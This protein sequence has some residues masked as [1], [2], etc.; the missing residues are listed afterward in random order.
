MKNKEII[1]AIIFVFVSYSCSNTSK[2]GQKNN[3][4]IIKL[5]G[6]TLTTDES[7]L[8]SSL[9]LL[10]DSMFY[11]DVF[12]SN[13]DTLIDVRK[14]NGNASAKQ[15]KFLSKGIGPF[16]FLIPIFHYDKNKCQL[17]ILER[18]R[19][20]HAYKID[21]NNSENI[22]NPSSW[23]KI[24]FDKITNFKLG[25]KFSYLSDTMILIAGGIYG[26][27]QIL[28]LININNQTVSSLNFWPDDGFE[29]NI[30]VKQSVYVENARI[31][32]NNERN[33]ILYVSGD[34][35]L[36]EILNI[37]DNEITS[38]KTIFDIFPTYTV[39]E[40]GINYKCKSDCRR[41][42]AVNVTDKFIYLCHGKEIRSDRENYKGYPYYYVDQIS[43][44]DWDGNPVKLYE[45]DTPFSS[46]FVDETENV[47]YV[48]SEDLDTDDMIIRKYELKN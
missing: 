37:Q 12:G 15:K 44:Y 41:G 8:V 14:L 25:D 24:N 29:E 5:N 18:S 34:G 32:T 19:L 3:Q 20:S 23:E 33:K 39:L 46:L 48:I 38:K 7:L 28:S 11:M 36:V 6:T 17:T 43:V 31:F 35:V 4:E 42:Y 21:L 1:W 47:M 2:N 16:E 30:R 13:N 26:T 27:K 10:K 40:D 9:I 22:Y 45:T